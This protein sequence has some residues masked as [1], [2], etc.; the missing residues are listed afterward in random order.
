M[1]EKNQKISFRFGN[2]VI[3][4]N[5]KK[6]KY[7]LIIIIGIFVLLPYMNLTMPTHFFTTLK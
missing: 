2:K 1:I 3:E 7:S 4:I 5:K 6:F